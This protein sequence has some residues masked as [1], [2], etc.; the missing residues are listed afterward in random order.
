MS[1]CIQHLLICVLSVLCDFL[2]HLSY[3]LVMG[4]YDVVFLFLCV[5]YL[6][7]IIDRVATTPLSLYNFTV[8]VTLLTVGGQP[9]TSFTVLSITGMSVCTSTR[10][11]YGLLQP[12][13]NS[14]W[15]GKGSQHSSP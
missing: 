1:G 4:L 10:C 13:G 8:N 11:S 3:L 14:E 7:P 12:V 5:L 9:I 15:Y 6:E 2:G